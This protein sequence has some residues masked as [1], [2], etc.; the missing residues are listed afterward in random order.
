LIRVVTKVIITKTNAKVKEKN[1]F[2]KA[3]ANANA[4]T[5]DLV[6]FSWIRI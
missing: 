1:I 2:T 3:K 4:K 6:S 5:K